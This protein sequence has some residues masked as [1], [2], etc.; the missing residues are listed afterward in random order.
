MT[1]VQVYCHKIDL[2]EKPTEIH[3][4]NLTHFQT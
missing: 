4:A 1:T 3:S 2:Y